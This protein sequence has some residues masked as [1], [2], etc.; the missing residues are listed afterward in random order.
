MRRQRR[1]AIVLLLLAIAAG[2]GGA[3]A[4][5][6]GPAGESFPSFL[7]AY[8]RPAL[9]ID[10]KTLMLSDHAEK[11][12]VSRYVYT[13]DDQVVGLTI[14][15]VQC[16][17]PGC[18]AVYDQGIRFFNARITPNGG[19]FKLITRTEFRA[20]WQTGLEETSAFVFQLPKSLLFWTYST[21][22]H[23]Q[24]DLDGYFRNL[25]ELVNRERYEATRSDNVEMGRWGPQIHEYAHLLLVQGRQSDG[26][27]VLRNLLA[28]S[29]FDYEAH[30]ELAE[31]TPDS[32]AA[33]N[34]ATIVYANAESPELIARA[35]R[36]LNRSEPG[37]AAL[38]LLEHGERGLQL[39][40][41]PLEPCDTRLLP[42]AATIYEQITG[43]SVKVRRLA[44]PWLFGPPDRVYGQKWLQQTIIQ[45]AGVTNFAGWTAS[46]YRDELLKVTATKD[47]LSKYWV[48]DFLAKMPGRP[49]QYRVDPYLARLSELLDRYRSDDVRTMYVGV[50][51]ANIFSGE[52]N[53]IFSGFGPQGGRAASILSY[54]M[55]MAKTLGEPYESRKRLAE[56]MAK[57]LVPAS[58]KA[59]GIPRPSDPTDPYSYSDGVERLTQKTL[60]LSPPT[61]AALDKFR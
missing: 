58:L 47:A 22:L 6:A 11:D 20:D 36:V 14:E 44:E 39:I 56:R 2:T 52:N 5:P 42:E 31:S 49:G 29:P 12:K 9:E 7:P 15:S 38:P 13:S 27:A 51:E 54:S 17:G 33:R 16:D 61:K 30:L 3:Q 59:L 1:T 45:N 60:T 18:A 35:A 8:F 25:Q 10:G 21:R 32:A 57:E 24:F 46:R 50:T 28:T 48:N 26:L 55:M 4:Q 34:S 53:F 40:L 23:R 19:A 37:I 43:V 41:I